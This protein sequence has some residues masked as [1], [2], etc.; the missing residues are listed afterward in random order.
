MPHNTFALQGTDIERGYTNY[1]NFYMYKMLFRERE[2]LFDQQFQFL[3]LKCY[4]CSK[5][6]Y[7]T[8][9]WWYMVYTTHGKPNNTFALKG[10]DISTFLI[11]SKML[12]RERESL[13]DQQC[14]VMC[15]K[16]FSERENHFLTKLW[17]VLKTNKQMCFTSKWWFMT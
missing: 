5:P 3:N 17:I 11:K 7:V 4:L 9:K 8:S 13:F 14:V 2:S 15:A 6:M 12:F 10:T 16:C 1:S